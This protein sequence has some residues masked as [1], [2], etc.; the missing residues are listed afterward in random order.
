MNKPNTSP[1]EAAEARTCMQYM[2]ARH[3][4]FTHVRNETGRPESS[5]KIRNWRAIFDFQDGVSPGFPDFVIVLPGVGL[6]IVELKRERGG[7]VSPAQAE[8][9][10]A[11]NSCP[12]VAAHVCR[13]SGDFIKTLESY[14]PLPQHI[15]TPLTP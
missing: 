4:K 6:L 9:V 12:G 5:G 13:G 11:L 2:Q 14:Y 3:L 7:V 15:P 10:E 1:L 8:W